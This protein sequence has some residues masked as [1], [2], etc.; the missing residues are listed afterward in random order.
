VRVD[1]L[2]DFFANR[3]E[4]CG[5]VDVEPLKLQPMW[6]N[7]RAGREIVLKCLDRFMVHNSI[8]HK[9]VRYSLG[10]I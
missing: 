3:L 10:L 7:N 8:L 9:V 1:H 4:A 6:S 2:A 5:L